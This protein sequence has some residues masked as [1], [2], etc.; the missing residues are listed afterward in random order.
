[1]K[2]YETNTWLSKIIT[3]LSRKFKRIRRVGSKKKC[4][5]LV[6][7]RPS[8]AGSDSATSLLVDLEGNRKLARFLNPVTW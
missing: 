1:M 3:N 8:P 6:E 7:N 5:L 2:H 4:Y